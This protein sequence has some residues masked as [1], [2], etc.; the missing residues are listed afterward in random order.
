MNLKLI[1]RWLGQGVNWLMSQLSQLYFPFRWSKTAVGF[2]VLVTVGIIT[3]ITLPAMSQD[4][5]Q[6]Q[7]QKLAQK[8]KEYYEAGKLARA[9]KTWQ[10]ATVAYQDQGNLDGSRESY[11]NTATAQQALGLYPQSCDS[12]LGAFDLTNKTSCSNIIEQAQTIEPQ[13]EGIVPMTEEAEAKFLPD[14]SDIEQYPDSV[15]KV[16]GLLRF[17]DYL[18]ESGYPRVA[19]KALE[20]G[21]ETTNRLDDP[22]QQTATLLSLGNTARAI[23]IEKQN[24]FPPQTV[25]LDTIANSGGSAESALTPYQPALSYYEQAA[26]TSPN[27]LDGLKAELNGLSLLLD[28]KD[29]WQDAIVELNQNI[30]LLEISDPEFLSQITDG[31]ERLNRELN[32]QL[33]PQITAAISKIE[34]EVDSFPSTRAGI[35]GKINFAQ[36]LIRQG[37]TDQDTAE[38]LATAIQQSREINNVIAEAEAMGYLGYLYEQQGQYA[39]ASRLTEGSLQLAPTAEYPEVAYRWNSQL[40]RILAAQGKRDNALNAYEASF[41][42][43]KALRSDLATTPVEPIFR[44]YISLLLE[45]EPTL[46]QLNQARDV[47]ESLQIVKLDNFF[48]DPCSQVAEEPVAIDDV[49]SEAA[50]IYPILLQDRLEVILTLPGQPLRHYETKNLTQKQ[51]DNT[52]KK[53]RRRSLTNPGFAEAIRGARGTDEPEAEIAKIKR[54]QEESLQEDILPLASEIY[55]WLIEPAEEDL[56]AS[57]VKTLVFVLD[58]SLRNIPMSLLYDQKEQQYLIEKDYNI[59]L[60]SGLQLTNPQPL[61]RQQIRVLA[62]GV[63]NEFP[64]YRFPPIPKVED[65]LKEIKRIFNK[66]EILLNQDFTEASLQEKLQESDFPVVHL[67]THGQ[68]GSTSDQTFIL[69]GAKEGNPLINVN[70]FDNL[71]RAGNLKRS[72]PIELLVLSAC[73]TAEGDSQAILGLAGVAVR[74]GAR[75]TLATLWGANDEATANLMGKFYNNLANDVQIS[76]ARALRQAQLDLLAEEDSQYR[77][78]YYWAPFVLVGNWL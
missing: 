70:R 67:A 23:A 47:L 63:T 75:S 9:I 65:E 30:N 7:P 11:L 10:K 36:S 64:A 5:N 34:P 72:Q 48:R 46:P 54:S 41:N 12:L 66:S 17:G 3:A 15:D 24:Q 37:R 73:N 62:A 18:R 28:I 22:L 76:K 21:L 45:E 29:F 49:D 78:P 19:S 38:I 33:N 53:L 51:V 50:V 26:Q 56:K 6:V 58:G 77:H 20:M 43:I 14:V 8:G 25:V 68:F 69:S 35:Y 44:D 59:A 52:I 16:T 60:S 71:L 55:S 39:E 57:G 31:S 13:L 4:V 61:K 74:A 1:L 32:Q 2:M 27:Q 40:G 42:T